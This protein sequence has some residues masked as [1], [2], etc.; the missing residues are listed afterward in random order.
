MG[1]FICIGIVTSMT[2]KKLPNT[3]NDKNIKELMETLQKRG[4]YDSEVFDF[5][6]DEKNYNFQLKKE[7]FDRD[8]IPFLRAIYPDLYSRENEIKDYTNT[9]KD[10]E[11]I[12][13]NKRLEWIKNDCSNYTLEYHPQTY[14]MEEDFIRCKW[15]TYEVFFDTITLMGEGK[16]FFECF[17]NIPRYFKKLFIKSYK[18]FKL[19][20][21][22]KCYIIG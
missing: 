2:I 8:L 20:K 6:E 5:D 4:I 16:V 9:I 11:S 17:G 18:E 19:S 1:Q 7:V 21:A 22:L 3:S 12:N 15:S 14:P 10:L 13:S